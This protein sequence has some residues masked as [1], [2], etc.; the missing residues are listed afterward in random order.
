MKAYIFI[1]TLIFG[2]YCYA[3]ESEDISLI[4]EYNLIDRTLPIDDEDWNVNP[5]ELDKD[6]Y[7]FKNQDQNLVDWKNIDHEEWLNIKIWIRGRDSKDKFPDWHRRLREEKNSEVIGRT[8]KCVGTCVKFHGTVRHPVE[9]GVRFL[10]GDEVYTESDSY[11]WI[12]LTDGSLLKVMPETSVTINEFNLAKDKTTVLMRLNE[13]NIYY[14]PRLRGEFEALDRVESDLTPYPLR[15]SKANREYHSMQEYRNLNEA[16]RLSYSINKNPGYEAQYSFLNDI[17]KKN[18]EKISK[19][20][21][22]LIYTPNLTLTGVNSNLNLFYEPNGKSY[23]Y[24][25]N[26]ISHFNTSEKSFELKAYFRGYNNSKEQTPK[27]N[28]WYMMD[29][30]GKKLDTFPNNS[31]EFNYLNASTQFY[32]RIP[33]IQLARE[34]LIEKYLLNTLATDIGEDK[35]A[36]DY[37]YRLWNIQKPDELDK[38][39]EFALEYI[40]RVETTNLNA[41]AHIHK[42]KVL[43]G[44]DRKFI[45]RAMKDHFYKLKKRFREANL[46]VREMTDSEYY[47]WMLKNDKK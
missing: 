35:L 22:F 14:Q 39:R 38:R 6:A 11:L 12:M 29:K 10:E 47:I 30:F 37:G 20:T 36:L 16:E 26:K 21:E 31:T 2:N 27:F 9:F 7:K 23:F 25:Q 44:F 24:A 13:G 4:Q 33:T 8:I 42:K 17:H 45:A 19:A 46:A 41:L 32:E 28:Q 15:I 5:L 3:L 18:S 40:R 1:F 34:I 43:V